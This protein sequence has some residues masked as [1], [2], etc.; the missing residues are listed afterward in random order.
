VSTFWKVASGV[1]VLVLLIIP[2]ILWLWGR[3]W[4]KG[5]FSGIKSSQP[6]AEQENKSE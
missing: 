4:S 1:A 2:G 5:L 6:K 3:A